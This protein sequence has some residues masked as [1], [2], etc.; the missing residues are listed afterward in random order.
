MATRLCFPRRGC[1][2]AT[3]IPSMRRR[4]C[5]PPNRG[6]NVSSVLHQPRLS[7]RR[8]HSSRAEFSGKGSGWAA[9]QVSPKLSPCA[10]G[11]G[12]MLQTPWLLRS[13]RVTR[14]L[15][16][17]SPLQWPRCQHPSGP[18]PRLRKRGALFATVAPQG[19]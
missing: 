17:V 3:E 12:V 10:L 9:G 14:F 18:S 7:Q 16:E 15:I 11:G 4:P 8:S 2:S 19:T 5:P 13:L 1:S 6:P